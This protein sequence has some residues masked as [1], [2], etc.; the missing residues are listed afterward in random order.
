VLKKEIPGWL[1]FM[2]WACYP[3]QALVKASAKGQN[4]N[5]LRKLSTHVKRLE[6]SKQ[7]N[8]R[9]VEMQAQ[10]GCPLL[11]ATQV[12]TGDLCSYFYCGI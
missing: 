9:G 4:I 11:R 8:W 10:A 2:A 12:G 3:S 6:G 7:T 1:R 5:Y